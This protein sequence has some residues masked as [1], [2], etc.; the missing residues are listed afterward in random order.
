MSKHTSRIMDRSSAVTITL[1][2]NLDWP[3]VEEYTDALLADE[4]MAITD[5]APTQIV[6]AWAAAIQE[7]MELWA[8][9]PDSFLDHNGT[10]EKFL[11][12][13]LDERSALR[14]GE[15]CNPPLLMV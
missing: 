14:G 8:E 4:N 7:K 2:L 12:A 10:E 13:L 5:F 9:D 3:L 15:D 6:D 1:T 11:H